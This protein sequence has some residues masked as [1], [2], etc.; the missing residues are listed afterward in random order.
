ME[1]RIAE[2]AL[3]EARA[4][5][6]PPL[7]VVIADELRLYV[8][9]R[10][11]WRQAVPQEDGDIL[12]D[13]ERYI[14]EIAEEV[15]A[16]QVLSWFQTSSTL[17]IR[18]AATQKLQLTDATLAL[19]DLYR[20]R[21]LLQSPKPAD[22]EV[23]TENAYS[24][25][26]AFAAIGRF[27]FWRSYKV[28][29]VVAVPVAMVALLLLQRHLLLQRYPQIS[30]PSLSQQIELPNTIAVSELPLTSFVNIERPY[31][32]APLLLRQPIRTRRQNTRRQ[33][34]PVR[35]QFE[36]EFTTDVPPSVSRPAI[37]SAAPPLGTTVDE[38]P[39]S[40]LPIPLP[41]AAPYHTKRNR[42]LHFF[43]VIFHE[44]IPQNDEVDDKH[45]AQEHDNEHEN[46]RTA[47]SG[48][49]IQGLR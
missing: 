18:I 32:S 28:F 20:D 39:Q 7:G 29:W 38:T 24:P 8:R 9:M 34:A 25:S 14:P 47:D 40:P 16:V 12:R 4:T 49:P 17:P 10:P 23:D 5:G 19:E 2:F 41:A 36:G 13:Y 6:I 22:S 35:R 11:D 15:G 45:K 21:V 30:K 44:K 26:T 1:G 33:S 42:F 27:N 48:R 31:L 3:L 46:E 43:S 37:L